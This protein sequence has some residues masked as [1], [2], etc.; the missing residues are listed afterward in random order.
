MVPAYVVRAPDDEL[1]RDGSGQTTDVVPFTADATYQWLAV[2]T[3]YIPL[4]SLMRPHRVVYS[5]PL[6]GDSEELVK[7]RVQGFVADHHIDRS[8]V[9]SEWVFFPSFFFLNFL[10]LV[11]L[12]FVRSFLRTFPFS[13]VVTMVYF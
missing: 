3:D 11:W 4:R 10:A 2:L 9:G 6:A 8:K 1:K 5:G 12:S 7:I 13:C